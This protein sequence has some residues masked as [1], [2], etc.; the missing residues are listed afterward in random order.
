MNQNLGEAAMKSQGSYFAQI[1]GKQAYWALLEEVYTTPK[2]GLVDKYSC[3]AHKDMDVAAF[4]KSARALY[5]FFIQMAAFGYEFYGSFEELFTNIRIIG[6]KAERAMYHATNGVNTHRGLLFTLG[7]FCA[8]AGRCMRENGKITKKMLLEI[9]KKMTVRILT[10]ELCILQ[11]Q[12][13][14]SNGERN[15]KIYGS[16]GI[17]GEAIQGYPA[18]WNIALPVL[19]QGIREKKDW[20]LVKLQ[21]L[22]SL[23]SEVEDS[24]IIS[25]QNPQILYQVHKEAKE[26]LKQGGAYS[27][28]AVKK[29]QLMDEDYIRK[30]IS[31]GGCADLLAATIFIQAICEE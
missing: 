15:L 21:T 23:M 20:N 31:A 18:I 9:E 13:A 19:Q 27:R 1:I 26:F 17:R 25:R 24:N 14:R 12:N 6:V 11:T 5:P 28:D 3:G 10:R 2:P 7:I 4:E 16:T 8:A 30:N 29:L 22:F